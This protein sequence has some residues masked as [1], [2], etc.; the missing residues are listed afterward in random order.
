MLSITKKE[1]RNQLKYKYDNRDVTPIKPVVKEVP[2]SEQTPTEGVTANDQPPQEEEKKI[3]N[4][5]LVT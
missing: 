4:L 5:P 3:S 1:W 2:E